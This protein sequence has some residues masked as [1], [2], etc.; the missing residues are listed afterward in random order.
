[1]LK[2]KRKQALAVILAAVMCS[3]Q[4]ALAAELIQEKQAAEIFTDD[5]EIF[6]SGAGGEEEFTEKEPE[7]NIEILP[8]EAIDGNEKRSGIVC[9]PA[10]GTVFEPILPKEYE[11]VW[12]DGDIEENPRRDI[13]IVNNGNKPVK[14]NIGEMKHFF[15]MTEKYDVNTGYEGVFP[16]QEP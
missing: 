12:E 16:V 3:G 8:E 15:T 2:K 11:S 9:T 5:A 6:S 4:Q 13:E 10:N 1:M 7:E 14:V